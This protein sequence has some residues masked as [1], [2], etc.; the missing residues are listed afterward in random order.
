MALYKLILRI[1]AVLLLVLCG[2]ALFLGIK[3]FQQRELLKNRTQKLEQ[4]VHLLAATIETDDTNQEK[5]KIADDQLKVLPGMEAPL[6]QI[7]NAA[8]SQLARLNR[9]RGELAET[10]TALEQTNLV[11]QAT[12]ADLGAAKA[13]IQ[14]LNDVVSA[15]TTALGEKE[16]IVKNLER[17]KV[18]LASK[19]D[20]LKLQM[21][22]LE[23]QERDL[24]DQVAALKEKVEELETYADPQK[25]TLKLTKGQQ[26]VIL[27]VDPEWNFVIFRMSPENVKTIIPAIE[28]LV[29]RSDKLVGKVRVAS[30]VE[31]LAVAEIINDWQQVPLEKGDHI[32]H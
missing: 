19:S 1:A 30:I 22:E 13:S 31:N 28:L 8:Q 32:M 3:L 23:V 9:T 15:K 7:H 24:T 25:A 11:L 2:V 17:E 5:I 10:K 26:G 4:T 12:V 18:E 14:E 27:Y 29:H 20:A 16:V 6:N 21:D